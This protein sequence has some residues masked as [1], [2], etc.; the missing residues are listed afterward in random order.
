MLGNTALEMNVTA[1]SRNIRPFYARVAAL[2]FGLIA[3]SG[4]VG[5]VTSIASGDMVENMIFAVVFVVVGLLAAAAAWSARR[6]GLIVAAV[7]SLALLAL[8]VPFA[9][10]IL[11]HPE[12][13]TEFVPVVLMLAGGALALVG[14]VVA[15]V[16]SW[17]RTAYSDATGAERVAL[18]TVLGTVA[19]AALFSVI[20][21]LTSRTS[22]PAEA[23]VGAA[24]MQTK[25]FAFSPQSLQAKG[26]D[27]VRVIVRNDDTSLHTFTLPAVGFDVAIPPGAER[28]IEFNAPAKGIYQWYCIPHSQPNGSTR[29]GMVGTL[30][31][32]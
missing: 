18:A 29:E 9:L 3:L 13:A 28:V 6:W 24:S 14:S 1:D 17:R 20:L 25:N 2:G 30:F 11:S 15:L 16:R 31:V 26:N 8:V 5:V 4:L 7:L 21:T 10:F 22:I 27:R 19:M 12:S 32:Q 23:R